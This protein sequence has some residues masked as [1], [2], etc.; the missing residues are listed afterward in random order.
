MGAMNNWEATSVVWGLCRAQAALYKELR[1]QKEWALHNTSADCRQSHQAQSAA[2]QTSMH[3]STE[4][5]L[6]PQPDP[7]Q[8]PA[9]ARPSLASVVLHFRGKIW[10][11]QLTVQK[12]TI[13]KWC[14]RAE[15]FW[16]WA[17]SNTLLRGN[18]YWPI[19]YT[20]R[21]VIPKCSRKWELFRTYSLH[22]RL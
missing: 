16:G 15:L 13:P 9:R 18:L 14:Y 12:G 6:E 11:G 17:G 7:A 10:A 21:L 3:S 19:L 2:L 4:S 20:K 1:A 8:S 22:A 5:R